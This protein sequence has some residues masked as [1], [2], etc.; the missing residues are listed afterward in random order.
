M[1]PRASAGMF[2]GGQ[3]LCITRSSRPR[4]PRAGCPP[5]RAC[6]A[7]RRAFLQAAPGDGAAR[8]R[9][10]AI[11]CGEKGPKRRRAQG[12]LPGCTWNTV[13]GLRT[14]RGMSGITRIL[15]QLLAF[16]IWSQCHEQQWERGPLRNLPNLKENELSR[17][18]SC[19]VKR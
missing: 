14:D 19:Q 8:A 2:T 17:H 11:R 7:W 5:A 15:T 4:K 9:C 3:L 1:R 13:R 6:S 10:R 12:E 18:Q 16:H